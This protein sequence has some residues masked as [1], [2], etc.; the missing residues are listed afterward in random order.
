LF[1]FLVTMGITRQS[2]YLLCST[3]KASPFFPKLHS[4]FFSERY[5]P[6]KGKGA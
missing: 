3:N 1:F 2:L 4:S 5:L 6:A